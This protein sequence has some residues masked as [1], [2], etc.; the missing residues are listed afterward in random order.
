MPRANTAAFGSELWQALFAPRNIAL[1]GQSDNPKRPSGRPLKYLRRDGYDG[2]VYPI[3]PRR[4]TVQGET[5][6]SGLQD[7]PARPDHAYIL[8]D[9]DL[10][11]ESFKACCEAGVPVVQI[12]A[13]G[14]AESGHDGAERQNAL[15]AMAK[16]AGVRLL[17]PNCMG[18][19][20]LNRGYS[21]T[22]NAVFD[23]GI[24]RG[25]RVALISTSLSAI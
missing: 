23:E 8:L 21:L 18:V 9:T 25:G 5:A 14:F 10:A 6:W 13:D 11:V 12:L 19:A 20:D 2:N 4:K 7:L 3:N 17:G 15:V 1:I 24:V 22:V 16:D